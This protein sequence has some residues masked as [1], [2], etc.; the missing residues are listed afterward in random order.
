M[1]KLTCKQH[2]ADLAHLLKRY[3]TRHVVICPGSRN[4]PLIQVFQRD[5]DFSCH[6]IVDERS[7]GYLALGIAR[8]TGEP[9]AIVTTS[10]TAALN[11]APAV[12]EA[13]Y[14]Q[15]PLV[16][17]TAD[18]PPEWPPQFGNQRINQHEIYRA[19]AKGFLN[20]EVE[21]V[22]SAVN[23]HGTEVMKHSLFNETTVGNS[24]PEKMLKEASA[25]I[26]SGLAAPRGPVHI[27]LV[28]HEPLYE[29]IGAPSETARLLPIGEDLSDAVAHAEESMPETARS[30]KSTRALS[31]TKAPPETIRS[32]QTEK[33]SSEPS[34]LR[35]VAESPAKPPAD[36]RSVI[37]SDT[38]AGIIAS[39]LNSQKKVLLI[40]GMNAYSTEEKQLLCSL[41]EH[42]QVVVIAENITNLNSGAPRSSVDPCPTK[43]EALNDS[44]GGPPRSNTAPEPGTDSPETLS[45][46][47]GG[48][49]SPATEQEP[50]TKS[51]EALNHPAGN[52]FISLPELVLA[53]AG[54]EELN[55][56][57]PDL[58]VTFGLQVVS[59]RT[60]LFVQRLV[61]VPVINCS[62][63]PFALLLEILTGAESKN[64]DDP[65]ATNLSSSENSSSVDAI[66]EPSH[67][68]APT[69][70]ISTSGKGTGEPANNN[71]S[72]T[73]EQNLSA[74]NHFLAA[75][76]K[77]ETIAMHR[78]AIFF[79]RADFSNLTASA[80]IL[81]Q[82]PPSTT[83]HLGN[84][85]TIRY[86]Q[87]S[88]TRSDLTFYSNRGTSGIDGSLSAAVGAA[89]VSPGPHLA[90]LGD[91][92]FVYDS[93]A[94]WN[95]DF[96]KNLKI[97]VLNDQGG[98]IFRLLDGPSRM[99]FFG[100]FS[101]TNHPVDL[102]HLAE[103]FGLKHLYVSDMIG[104]KTALATL[105]SGDT[106]PALLEV[107]TAKSENSAIFKQF[108]KSLQNE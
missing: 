68:D 40:A 38:E 84:S 35:P 14:L 26:G 51:A 33:A 52:R 96:P 108:F 16:V 86:A 91:L 85:G 100:E 53:S 62:Q 69:T 60:R 34:R 2:I 54:A 78:A 99:P 106:G 10:G 97:I 88:A 46:P 70:K 50:R 89:M 4:A 28:L 45:N 55:N 80:A 27:N 12:A 30:P 64:T 61:N 9:V 81:S 71:P 102:Q 77:Q 95:K 11:L 44:A 29:T 39:C 67:E 43:P 1:T 63:L 75:W 20:Q 42:Y 18:R 3:G 32:P 65:S 101:V 107:N 13:F 7:A 8:Q 15:L 6:S 76:K 66:T 57:T 25:L 17:L 105:F 21:P 103:A 37:L 19:N 49:S 74:K 5:T 104:L 56:L 58:V 48:P 94:L 59:K 82:I 36:T 72:R 41:T 87:L 93:N 24:G 90:I 92:S 79:D 22:G 23:V 31:E 83:V 47:A 73:R 98:G